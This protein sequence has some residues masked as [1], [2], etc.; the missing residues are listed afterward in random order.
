MFIYLANELNG[1]T[2][3][4]MN[5]YDEFFKN[6]PTREIVEAIL[7][8]NIHDHG[9]SEQWTNPTSNYLIEKIDK[10]LNLNL[11]ILDIIFS[12]EASLLKRSSSTY[13]K[14]FRAEMMDCLSK[15]RCKKLSKLMDTLGILQLNKYFPK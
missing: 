12:S 3:P 1:K 6:A 5:S 13:L 9:G 15:S 10:A 2:I 7:N 11:G 14:R 4:R 8:I